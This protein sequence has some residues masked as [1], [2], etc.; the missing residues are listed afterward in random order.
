M[1]EIRIFQTVKYV[2]A[3]GP[4]ARYGLWV[5]GCKKRCPGCISP[6]GQPLDGG[7]VRNIKE[8]AEEILCTE[9]IEGITISG[10]EPF[11]QKEGLVKLIKMIRRKKDLGV[12]L[13]TGFTFEEIAVEELT[14]VCDA[15]IDGA[16]IQE[17]NDGLSLRGSSNQRLI[18][19]SPRYQKTLQIGTL[20]RKIQLCK[21]E[22]GELVFVGI[23][24]KEQE[25]FS[26]D[27]Q[28]FLKEG[29]GI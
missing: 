12:I 26:G 1:E 6:E 3:L 5:Q 21:T 15:I 13:Y 20:R 27:L 9:N 8:L 28:R 25:Q 18:F 16:Y 23:P 11:L 7:Y 14:G 24:S 22:R 10:G 4:F 19:L 2:T 29:E 17:K